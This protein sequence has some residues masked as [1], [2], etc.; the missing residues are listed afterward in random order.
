MQQS[1]NYFLRLERVLSTK[2]LASYAQNCV[3]EKDALCLYIWNIAIC[4]SL[5]PSFQLLEVGFRNAIHR[6]IAKHASNPTWLTSEV[7]FLRPDEVTAIRSAKDAIKTR[8]RP[9]TEDVLIAELRF[10]FWTSLLDSHYELMWHKIIADVFPYMPKHDRLRREASKLMQTVRRLR[11]SALHHHSIWHWRDLRD[12]HK[13]MHIMIGYICT[14]IAVMAKE[15]D[16]FPAIYQS[17]PGQLSAIADA[18]IISN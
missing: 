15:V 13:Q 17:G 6:E 5:Y 4:E 18:I 12:Q 1:S 2:R 9:G 11:N 16:R 8:A 7:G 3:T 10:G 14:S